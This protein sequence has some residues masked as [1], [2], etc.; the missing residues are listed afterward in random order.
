MNVGVGVYISKKSL[1][2]IS[3]YVNTEGG[4]KKREKRKKKLFLYSIVLYT[5][6]SRLN[7]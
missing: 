6:Y 7:F 3:L 2:F 5:T 1:T 4:E